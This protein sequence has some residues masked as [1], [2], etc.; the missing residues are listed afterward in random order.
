M[1]GSTGQHSKPVGSYPGATITSIRGTQADD[2]AATCREALVRT[3]GDGG[4]MTDQS[5]LGRRIYAR[6]KPDESSEVF[7][8]RVLALIKDAAD[9]GDSDRGEPE[10]A[11]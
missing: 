8:H 3:L 9:Q 10:A 6:P 7:G 5:E 1:T 4:R 2:D 11:D